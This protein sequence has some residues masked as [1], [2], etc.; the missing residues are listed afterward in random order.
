MVGWYISII[1][2]RWMVEC[3]EKILSLLKCLIRLQNHPVGYPWST[4]W[5][6][7]QI[8]ELVY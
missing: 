1:K 2:Y 6:V 7:E 3:T 4:Y 8:L 5:S